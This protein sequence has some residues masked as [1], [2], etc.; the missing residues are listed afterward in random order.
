MDPK[1]QENRERAPGDTNSWGKDPGLTPVFVESS[2]ND[3]PRSLT[4]EATS[5]VTA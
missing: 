3:G 2:C 4:P 1:G 5:K